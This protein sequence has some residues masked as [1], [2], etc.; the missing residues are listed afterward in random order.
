MNK[1]QK[2][3]EFQEGT[4]RLNACADRLLVKGLYVPEDFLT[5][6]R[7]ASIDVAT[8]LMRNFHHLLLR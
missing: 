6:P 7:L 8:A 3:V 4:Q 5:K 2:T 1:K